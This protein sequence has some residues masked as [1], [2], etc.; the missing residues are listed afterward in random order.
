[1][2]NWPRSVTPATVFPASPSSVN[3]PATPNATLSK[4]A[5]DEFEAAKQVRSVTKRAPHEALKSIACGKLTF[6]ERVVLHRVGGPVPEADR[7]FFIDNQLAQ[8]HFIIDII[9]EDQPHA[10]KV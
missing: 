3:A 4:E 7:E 6:D 9:L 8:I 5:R 2:T 10:M 1:M